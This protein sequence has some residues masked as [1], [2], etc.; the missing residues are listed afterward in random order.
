[1]VGRSNEISREICRVQE[2]DDESS[3]RQRGT[4]PEQWPRPD[5]EVSHAVRERTRR[6]R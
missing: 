4:L 1:M 6:Y 3:M 5:G 2:V